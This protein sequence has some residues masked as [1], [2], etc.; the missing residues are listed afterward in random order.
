MNIY[1]ANLSYDVNDNDLRELFSQFGNVSS[2]KIIN[3]RDTGRSRGFGFVEM[4]EREEALNAINELNNSS[5]EGKNISVS[6]ARPKPD[7]PQGGGGYGGGGG[8]NRNSGGGGGGFRND[9]RP[10]SW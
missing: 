6:E 9:R 3:D 8:G 2:A 4:P 10:K 7:R 5:H 1:V